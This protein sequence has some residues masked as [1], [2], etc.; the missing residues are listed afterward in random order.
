VF[1]S[2][3]SVAYTC[4]AAYILDT[5]SAL[6]STFV[7]ATRLTLASADISRHRASVCSSVTSRCSA[8]TDHANKATDGRKSRQ[9]SNGV[10]QTEAPNVGG[11]G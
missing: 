2:A 3:F 5:C 10:T 7:F 6:K 4:M 9:N 11:V 8:E 1:T